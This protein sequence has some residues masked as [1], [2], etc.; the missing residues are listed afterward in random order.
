MAAAKKYDLLV[1]DVRVVRPNKAS[2]QRSDIA[3]VDPRE[4]CDR[5]LGQAEC[6]PVAC[7][8]AHAVSALRRSDAS[9]RSS[10]ISAL[11]SLAETLRR[12]LLRD[13]SNRYIRRLMMRG[14]AS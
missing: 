13:C 11:R 14:T 7:W 6:E 1:K 4:G 8:L 12:P 9:L 10:A 3:I 2:V 5:K